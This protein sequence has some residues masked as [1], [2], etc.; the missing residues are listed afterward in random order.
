MQDN[1]GRGLYA[2]A[3][4]KSEGHVVVIPR[5]G[6]DRRADEWTYER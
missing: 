4:Q 2:Q 1:R 6:D 5:C 3:K